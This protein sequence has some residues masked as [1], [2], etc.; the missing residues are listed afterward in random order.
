MSEETV[1]NVEQVRAQVWAWLG[2]VP[3]PD[4]GGVQRSGACSG[5]HYHSDAG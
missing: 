4:L 1:T 2:D 3:D 5:V